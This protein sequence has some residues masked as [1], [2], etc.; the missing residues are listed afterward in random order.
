M[1]TLLSADF[2][3]KGGG[4]FYEYTLK[5]PEEGL[6]RHVYEAVFLKFDGTYNKLWTIT[7]ER[8]HPPSPLYYTIPG[9]A[10]LTMPPECI[11]LTQAHTSTR[12]RRPLRLQ[13][14]LQWT[15]SSWRELVDAASSRKKARNNHHAPHGRRAVPRRTSITK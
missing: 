15:R 7:G 1:S 9:A 2:G 10:Q 3:E 12:T 13:S 11:F 5:R 8:P 6:Y 14:R 4:Y